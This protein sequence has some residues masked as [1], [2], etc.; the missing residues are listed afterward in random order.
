MPQYWAAISSCTSP[1]PAWSSRSTW[2]PAPPSASQRSCGSAAWSK[3]PLDSPPA[4]P[5]CLF[6]ARLGSSALPGRGRPTGR[7]AA[8]SG[9][10]ASRLQSNQFHCVRSCRQRGA[11]DL[12]FAPSE[13]EAAATFERLCAANSRVAA[14]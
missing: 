1:W 11:S 10:R 3:R 4:R 12:S 9:A 5:L 13:A 6:R 7:P 14:K 8:A 2:P